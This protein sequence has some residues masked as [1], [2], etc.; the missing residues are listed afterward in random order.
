MEKKHGSPH[1]ANVFHPR[2]DI[3]DKE[4]TVRGAILAG[5]IVIAFLAIYGILCLVDSE[6]YAITSVKITVL[7]AVVVLGILAFLYGKFPTSGIFEDKPP[8]R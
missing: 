4:T 3:T 2:E 5:T 8:R 1:L 7:V 6:F